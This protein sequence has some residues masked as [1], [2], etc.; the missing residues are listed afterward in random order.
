MIHDDDITTAQIMDFLEGRLDSSAESRVRAALLRASPM[1]LARVEWLRAFGD[2]VGRARL[3]DPPPSVREALMEEFR[4]QRQVCKAEMIF[5]SRH[6]AV[7]VRG[8]GTADRWS[9][10]HTSS[11]ADVATDFVREGDT[12]SVRGQVLVVDDRH[13][14]QIHL[15]RAMDVVTEA[16]ADT[17]GQFDLG[18]VEPGEYRLMVFLDGASVA[19]DLAV[20]S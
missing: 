9:T 14:E 15:R 6:D 8:V 20:A 18:V 11:F 1:S 7:A 13:I 12:V 2:R 3:E 17:Y 5:D 16:P 4:R 10:I 19:L